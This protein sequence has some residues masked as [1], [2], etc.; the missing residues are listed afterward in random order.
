MEQIPPRCRGES[1]ARHT[2]DGVA[3]ATDR[4]R[5][6]PSE[7]VQSFGRLGWLAF[8]TQKLPFVPASRGPASQRD[9]LPWDRTGFASRRLYTSPEVPRRCSRW[10][11]SP[12]PWA[13][14]RAGRYFRDSETAQA[15]VGD[16]QIVARF[17]RIWGI[18]DRRG[19]YFTG[20]SGNGDTDFVGWTAFAA[21]GVETGDFVVV[22]CAA[23]HSAVGICG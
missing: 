18:S 8:Y 7:N 1:R 14:L 11:D 2:K 9:A 12:R 6:L 16:R 21:C 19:E 4:V 23:L 22:G 20:K 10:G 17:A 3:L 5:N 15:K 13:T